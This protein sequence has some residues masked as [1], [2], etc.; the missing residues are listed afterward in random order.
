MAHDRAPIIVV[1]YMVQTLGYPLL[2]AVVSVA[3][4]PPDHSW[5]L[6]LKHCVPVAFDT[7]QEEVFAAHPII[8][9]PPMPDQVSRIRLLS[10]QYASQQ[11]EIAA[12]VHLIS[13]ASS[14][15][16]PGPR[17]SSRARLATGPAAIYT[18]RRATPPKPSVAARIVG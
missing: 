9:N 15:S 12:S 17:A 7:L 18:T 6:K 13:S 3:N 14:S 2:V 5:S 10:L 16:S 11:S 1:G 4:R 8:F